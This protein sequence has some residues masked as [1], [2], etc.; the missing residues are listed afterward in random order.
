MRISLPSRLRSC[1]CAIA[2]LCAAAG[3]SAAPNDE[4]ALEWKVKAAFLVH[5]A[6]FTEWPA[7]KFATADAPIVFCVRDN[8]LLAAALD[9]ILEGKAIKGRAL[10]MRRE[11]RIE[12]MRQCHVAYLGGSPADPTAA[13]LATL[14]GSATLSIYEGDEHLHGGAIR[15]FLED[16]KVRFEVDLGVTARERLNLSS[17]LLNVAKVIQR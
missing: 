9:E 12:E 11:S 15:L 4:E 16:R 8:Q 6:R 17:R 1:V 7:D 13:V 10:A 3:A 14:T 5:F 2:L